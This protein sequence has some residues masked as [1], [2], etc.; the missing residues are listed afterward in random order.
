MMIDR[1][2]RGTVI[3]YPYLWQH[4][5]TGNPKD[6]PACVAINMLDRNGKTVLALAAIS[7]QKGSSAEG[8]IELSSDDLRSAGLSSARRAFVHLGEVNIDRPSNM[9]NFPP[10]ARVWGRL[11][12]KTLRRLSY[13]LAE[14]LK[15]KKVVVIKRGD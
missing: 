1:F 9:L 13:Q 11:T 14:N 5:S 6:R 7:D 15:T 3:S 10:G 12:E 2:R 4:D 8:A